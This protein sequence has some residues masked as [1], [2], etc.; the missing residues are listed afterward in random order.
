VRACNPWNKGAFA[1]IRGI[2]LKIVS[3]TFTSQKSPGTPAGT[4]IA[5]SRQG[6]FVACRD[7][8]VLEID[9]ISMEEEGFFTGAQFANMGIQPPERFTPP[10]EL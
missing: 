6:L 7:G 1:F 2:Q 3:V 4:L 8:H 9:M 5:G 10:P